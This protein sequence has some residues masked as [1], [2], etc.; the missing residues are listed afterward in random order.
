M[1]KRRIA[2]LGSTGS[3]GQNA[4][5]VAREMPEMFEITALAVNSN[6]DGLRAQAQ[7]FKPKHVAVFD[8]DKAKG[9]SVEGAK[10]LAPGVEGLCE[11]AASPDVDI[12]LTS[13]VGG[14][15]FA[16]LLAGLKAGKTVALANKEP[17]VMAGEQFMIEA[18]RWGG[19]I[20]PVDSEPS[21][22]FQCFGSRALPKGGLRG[23]GKM[24]KR[25]FLTASG[26][27]FYKRQGELDKV[28]P[29]EALKHP[30]WNMGKKITVDSATLMNKG[31]ELIEIKNLFDLTLEQVEIIIHHQSIIHGAV[32]FSDGSVIAQMSPPDMALPI[33]YAMAWPERSKSVIEPLNL[34]D[35]EKLTF[36]K[37]DFK[38]F[39]CLQLAYDAARAGGGMAAVL[40]AADEIAV[41][42]FIEGRIRFTDIAKIIETTMNG[43]KAEGHLPSFAEI[44]EIDQWARVK[45][46][47]MVKAIGAAV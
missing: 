21:A 27:A 23:Y 18:E 10:T 42:A 35:T 24:A 1:S 4:L 13:L 39:N 15:G 47:E 28:T 6:V 26:G 7:E 32:E 44:A 8:A 19:S 30:T 45:A 22:I 34:F 40:S 17:M 46:N 31:F 41:A 2:I 5:R 36:A 29:A 20:L 14:V 25:V 37:P 3:I 9:F 33:Q 38:K 16:P 11:M 12:V 43:H